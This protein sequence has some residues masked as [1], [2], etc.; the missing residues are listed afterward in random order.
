MS[1]ESTLNTQG[2]LE[3]VWPGM[4]MRV[5]SSSSLDKGAQGCRCAPGGLYLPLAQ[6]CQV[7]LVEH[8]QV[9]L[10]PQGF[11]EQRVAA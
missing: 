11:L 9:W 7:H 2:V 4:P 8:E 1:K 3:Q 6:V 5:C 10:N